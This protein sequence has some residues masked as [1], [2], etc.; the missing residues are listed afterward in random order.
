MLGPSPS[1]GSPGCNMSSPSPREN[2]CMPSCPCLYVNPVR[3]YHFFDASVSLQKSTMRCNPLII[4][5]ASLVDAQCVHPL[6]SVVGACF[7]SSWCDPFWRAA[8]GAG[9]R[10]GAE[11]RSAAGHLG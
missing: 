10:S 11:L 2:Q 1:P 5:D 3:V 9:L 8:P 4:D 6:R 7:G